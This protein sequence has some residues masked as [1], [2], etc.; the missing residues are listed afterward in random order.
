MAS[1]LCLF[2]P[3]TQGTEEL[4]SCGIALGF[5]NWRAYQL[6]TCQIAPPTLHPQRFQGVRSL[7]EG[8]SCS[9]SPGLLVLVLGL[10]AGQG[11][12]LLRKISV[13]IKKFWN[14]PVLA[15]V[16]VYQ[17]NCHAALLYYSLG[18]HSAKP[19]STCCSW[20]L[21][22]YIFLKHQGWM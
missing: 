1:Y 20:S 22:F 18:P 6:K 9:W 4:K 10:P 11:L 3:I 5:M 16:N 8:S 13:H 17:N 12:Q 7:L 14:I 15:E 21:Y 19:L 2:L